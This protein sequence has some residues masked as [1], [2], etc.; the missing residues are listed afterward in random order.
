LTINRVESMSLTYNII[1]MKDVVLFQL[2][3]R[4]N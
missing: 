3:S 2:V 1:T 4:E